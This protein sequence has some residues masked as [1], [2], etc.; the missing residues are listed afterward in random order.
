V[1]ASITT[2]IVARLRHQLEQLTT[3]VWDLEKAV[4]GGDTADSQKLL[5]EM[6]RVRHGLL[7][8]HTIA[9]L[10]SEA[11]GSLIALEIFGDGADQHRLI[12][13]RDQFNHIARVADGQK[14]YHQGVIEFYRTR[15]DTKMTIASERLAVIAAV[16]LPITA[17]SV[18]LGMNVIV[19][20]KTLWMPLLVLVVIM[21]GISG[22][23]L[24]WARRN[25]W[26]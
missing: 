1:S 23:M 25:G 9:L 11:F 2:G 6:F 13:L 21:L 10:N 22:L 26:W 19:N 4:T 16:T 14:N 24:A 15:T 20:D 12:D 7:A 17:L 18:V 8:V 5:E 3:E